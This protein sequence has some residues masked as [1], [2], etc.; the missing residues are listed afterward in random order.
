MGFIELLHYCFA[1]VLVFGTTNPGLPLFFGTFFYNCLLATATLAASNAARGSL[2]GRLF[3]TEG[4]SPGC[5][6]SSFAII[7]LALVY[8]VEC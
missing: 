1:H 3:H 7:Y 4:F 6:P 8:P 5:L 2:A